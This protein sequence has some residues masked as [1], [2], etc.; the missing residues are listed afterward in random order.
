MKQELTKFTPGPWAI[1]EPTRAYSADT[2]KIYSTVDFQPCVAPEVMP[3]NARLIAEAPAMYEALGKCL[4]LMDQM[5]AY[6]GVMALPDYA[7]FND[8]P[9]E[10]RA[11][12][13]RIDNGKA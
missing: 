13:G 7:L 3:K 6:I 11:I 5:S 9:M 4:T 1:S 8:A 12:L 2:V 10:A